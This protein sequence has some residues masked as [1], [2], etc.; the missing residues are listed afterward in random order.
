MTAAGA[1]LRSASP[2]LGLRVLT[3]RTA[4]KR[5]LRRDLY[6]NTIKAL[7]ESLE[8]TRTQD[9]WFDELLMQLRELQ[10]F[11]QLS[12]D[13]IA[14]A[15]RI[16]THRD[17]LRERVHAL[18]WSHAAINSND[19]IVA[20]A[21]EHAV[22][23]LREE[24]ADD[25]QA[26]RNLA[27][28]GSDRLTVLA[29]DR[30]PFVRF[31]RGLVA[32]VRDHQFADAQPASGYRRTDSEAVFGV[33]LAAGTRARSGTPDEVK[34][35]QEQIDA[36]REN[37]RRIAAG[38][39]AAAQDVFRLTNLLSNSLALAQTVITHGRWLYAIGICSVYASSF[40]W[41][42]QFDGYRKRYY[43]ERETWRRYSPI[44]VAMFSS[45]VIGSRTCCMYV[46][47][48]LTVLGCCC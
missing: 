48:P 40:S 20:Q 2:A 21:I 41:L 6:D 22:T 33:A 36:T 15:P 45:Y 35:Q 12:E 42:Q 13:T 34:R 23:L 47:L 46:D 31:A 19:E 27:L 10:A 43:E 4:R 32:L 17:R 3:V 26:M 24:E 16:L 39:S 30:S 5:V 29:D 11:D 14:R 7:L 25:V 8:K 28:P 1:S 9:E 18:M 37:G 38:S 44:G